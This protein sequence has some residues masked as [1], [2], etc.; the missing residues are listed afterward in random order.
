M[1]SLHSMRKL[2]LLMG[3]PILLAGTLL[4]DLA[5]AGDFLGG[6]ED[7]PLAPGL[8]EIADSGLSFDSAGG[9][10]VEAYAQ[11]DAESAEVLRFYAATLPQLGW[12][13]LSDTEYRREAEMLTLS[14]RTDGQALVIQFKISPE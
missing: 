13:R 1:V 5:H 11:G 3:A 14:P 8:S 6:Y 4:A 2:T 12:V 10:I 7:L 9:R